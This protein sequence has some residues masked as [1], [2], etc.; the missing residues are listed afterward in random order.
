MSQFDTISWRD[1]PGNKYTKSLDAAMI[2]EQGYI[3]FGKVRHSSEPKG[4]MCNV[5]YDRD[6]V[7]KFLIK[8]VLFA[9]AVLKK[10]AV[11]ELIDEAWNELHGINKTNQAIDD[12]AS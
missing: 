6:Y 4:K 7:I 9:L 8:R 2:S 3:T 12:V 10:E 5:V 11:D 1:L